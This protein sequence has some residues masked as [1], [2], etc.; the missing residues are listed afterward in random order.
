ML[1]SKLKNPFRKSERISLRKFETMFLNL[2][3]T[4]D[5]TNFEN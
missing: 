3:G 5:S 4:T 1:N 2:L